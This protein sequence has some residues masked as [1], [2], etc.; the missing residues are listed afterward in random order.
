MTF[1]GAIM[2][3][4]SSTTAGFVDPGLDMRIILKN[5]I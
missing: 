5:G 2:I 4:R 1:V 3:K